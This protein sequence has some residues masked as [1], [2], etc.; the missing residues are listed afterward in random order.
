MHPAQERHESDEITEEAAAPTWAKSLLEAQKR[1]QLRLED[2]IL[3]LL[4]SGRVREVD[5]SEVHTL[6]PLC[7]A[8]NG[9]KLR[10]I[11]DLRYINKFLQVPKFK[12]EDIRL[13]KDLFNIG[14]FFFK[15]HIRPCCFA[16][17]LMNQF[18]KILV[19]LLAM[20]DP[21]DVE[22]SGK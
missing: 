11:L 8:D 6:N 1:S 16:Q 3:D 9:E 18:S 5:L 2:E 20:N 21:L 4:D 19:I 7:V 15:F 12:C 10:L 13:I 22:W 17:N 14:D